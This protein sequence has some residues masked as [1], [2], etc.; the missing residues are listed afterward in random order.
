[1]ARCIFCKSET[2]PFRT[3]EHILPESLGGGDWALLPEGLFCDACQNKFGS[4]IE[5]QA[6]GDYPF[7]MLRVF[8]G[9]PTKKGKAPWLDSWEGTF[10]GTPY[11]GIIGYDPAPIFGKDALERGKTQVRIPAHPVRPNMVCRSLLKMGME[12]VAADNAEDAFLPKFDLARSFALTGAKP[13]RWWYVQRERPEEVSR[14]ITSGVTVKEW[15]ETVGLEVIQ[16]GDE[17]EVFHLSLLYLEMFTPLTSEVAPD[18]QGVEEP[19]FRLF[20]L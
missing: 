9:I 14:Y 2:G 12:V 19:E 6:L 3:R 1:M 13:G 8:L 7:S 18:M 15:Y 4:E 5:Q 11:S 20:W 10:V 17:Q 16:L